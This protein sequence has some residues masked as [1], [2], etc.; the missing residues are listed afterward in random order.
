MDNQIDFEHG[1]FKPQPPK[2]LTD[3]IV[4]IFSAVLA[5]ETLPEKFHLNVDKRRISIEIGSPIRKIDIY[6]SESSCFIYIVKGAWRLVISDYTEVFWSKYR[7][8][9]SKIRNDY[10]NNRFKSDVDFGEV[11]EM[12]RSMLEQIK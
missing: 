11:N 3:L 8:R 4:D 12:L 7:S 10:M 5:A 2:E 1:L 9:L 6:V